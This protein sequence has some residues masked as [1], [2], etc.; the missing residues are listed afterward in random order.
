MEHKKDFASNEVLP[1][2]E[3]LMEL[4]PHFDEE[5]LIDEET[6]ASK[7][8]A[9]FPHIAVADQARLTE[10]FLASEQAAADL[11]DATQ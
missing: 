3:L 9:L 10:E 2:N 7:V 5:T 8:E 4:R 1:I 6:V 11:S